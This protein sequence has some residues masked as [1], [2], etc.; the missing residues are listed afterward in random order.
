MWQECLDSWDRV[1]IAAPCQVAEPPKLATR[2][3]GPRIS[4]KALKFSRGYYGALTAIPARF[5]RLRTIV[6]DH[7]AVVLHT[8]SDLGA[9][10]CFWARWCG[11]PYGLDVRGDQSVN[12]QYLRERG[13]PVARLTASTF[14]LLFAWVRAR[15]VSAIYV[16]HELGERFP[17]ASG[18]PVSVY[19]DVRIPKEWFS[20]PRDYTSRQQPWKICSVG[21][22]ES[23]KGYAY[24]LEACAA[25]ARID[26]SLFT[27]ELIG[28]G[29]L[30]RDLR[31]QAHALGISDLVTLRGFVQWG[32]ALFQILQ[33]SD[34][35]VLPSIT[36]GMPRAA[37]EAMACGLPVIASAVGGLPEILPDKCLVPPA[38]STAL[39]DRLV[40]ILRHPEDLTQMSRQSCQ[41]AAA[42][43]PDFLRRGKQDFY[44]GLRLA[45]KES[46]HFRLVSLGEG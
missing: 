13:T 42:F 14:R 5:W 21:R 29:P 9:L 25:I 8:P 10:A 33:Q 6:R 16:S 43:H 36:E 19:S 17:L 4:F 39:A 1:T 7:D 22:L 46:K 37:I 23:Q 30:E 27:L 24:L 44:H 35:F 20:A 2:V 15:A 11:I 32:P 41:Q 26:R 3:D 28:K 34:L 18:H 40:E 31:E 38:N 45:A 12:T